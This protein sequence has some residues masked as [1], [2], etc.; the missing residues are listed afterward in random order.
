MKPHILKNTI[1][2]RAARLAPSMLCLTPLIAGAGPHTPEP[3]ITTPASSPWEF[4]IQPYA[5]LTAI[6]GS[7]GVTGYVSNIDASFSDILDVLEMSAALQFEA[8]NGR[9]G[10]IADVFYAELGNDAT[11]TGPLATNVDLDF[12]QVLAE[13]SVAYR[14]TEHPEGFVD[15]YAGIRYNYL[16]LELDA[17]TSNLRQQIRREGSA[18]KG[19]VDPILGVRS[20]WDLNEK[21]FLAG[22]GDIGGFG[23]GS[24]LTWSLQA[25]VGYRFTPHTHLEFGYRYLHT[26][27]EDGPFTYDIDQSGIYIGLGISF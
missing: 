18:D 10:I 21:W 16:D 27:F 7:T 8:R 4:R 17:R 14:V 3:V 25:T 26:D 2:S 6:D 1:L 15:L 24:D 5:W 13:L 23:V 19:W 11:L 9:W 20:Q 12:T 22:K